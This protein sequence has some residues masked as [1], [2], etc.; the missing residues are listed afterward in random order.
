MQKRTPEEMAAMLP[1]TVRF[2]AEDYEITPLSRKLARAWK[3]K[4]SVVV[5]QAVDISSIDSPPEGDPSEWMKDQLTGKILQAFQGIPD[6]LAELIFDYAPNLDKGKIQDEA[7]DEQIHVAFAAV[8]QLAFPFFGTV[9]TMMEM[10]KAS[11]A[12]PYTN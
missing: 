7:T 4:Y 1:I 5:A 12:S 3:Q 6:R 2:G 8:F 11:P 10:G 9:G